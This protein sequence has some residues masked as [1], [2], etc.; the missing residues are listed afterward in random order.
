MLV[1]PQ[2]SCFEG[3]TFLPEGGPAGLHPVL[4]KAPSLTQVPWGELLPRSRR[5]VTPLT[6]PRLQG[7]Q[8][9]LRAQGVHVESED[10]GSRATQLSD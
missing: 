9:G 2:A 5:V 7:P 1:V 8:G 4:V 6:C 10:C 3:S